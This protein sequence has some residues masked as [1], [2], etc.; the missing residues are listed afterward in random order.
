MSNTLL[1]LGGKPKPS[2]PPYKEYNDV[3]CAN[4]SVYSASKYNIGV[5]VFTVLSSYFTAGDDGMSRKGM[6]KIEGLKSKKVFFLTV[7]NTEK[8]ILKKMAKRIYMYK[9]SELYARYNLWRHN[10]DYDVFR[11]RSRKWYREVINKCGEIDIKP[12][13][14]GPSSG[15]ISLAIGVESEKYDRYIL[16]GFSFEHKK[17]YGGEEKYNPHKS[18]DVRFIKNISC[19]EKVLTTEEK[20]NEICNTTMI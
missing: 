19:Y 16:S 9:N 1:I 17:E 14:K 10:F 15:I 4:A 8:S 12:S 6:S 18:Y 20:V 7:R 5:P 2:I 11:S 3:A 13:D